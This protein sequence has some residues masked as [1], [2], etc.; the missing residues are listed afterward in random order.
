MGALWDVI[1][2][3]IDSSPYPPSQ[4]KV[5]QRIGV[6]PTTLANWRNP[7]EMPTHEHIAAIADVTN[8][9]YDRVLAAALAD[10]GYDVA[11]D[12]STRAGSEPRELPPLDSGRPARRAHGPSRSGGRGAAGTSRDDTASGS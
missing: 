8:T 1:Q 7:K 12:G 10:T 9:P 6:S 11:A 2:R 5:A 3:H 4:R